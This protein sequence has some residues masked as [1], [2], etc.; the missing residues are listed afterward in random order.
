M[1]DEQIINGQKAE[2]E[3]LN[4]ELQAMR[5][6]A[7]LYKAETERLEKEC[8]K[9]FEK[10]YKLDER[11][12]QRYAELYE[13]AKESIKSEAIKEFAERLKNGT[14]LGKEKKSVEHAIWIYEIDK[15]VEEM[16]EIHE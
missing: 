14:F 4:A 11:T 10:W 6:A 15:I 5:G 2:I 1:T 9:N 12:K 3:K 8:N 13:A 7:N 16:T